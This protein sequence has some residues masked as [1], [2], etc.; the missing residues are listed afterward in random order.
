MNCVKRLNRLL[1]VACNIKVISLFTILLLFTVKYGF[2]ESP[3]DGRPA[4]LSVH[5]IP[6][7]DIHPLTSPSGLD[8]ATIRSVY[9]LPNTGGSG[10]IAIIDAFDDPNIESDLNVFCQQFG[11]PTATQANFELHKMSSTISPATT[12]NWGLEISLDVE[13]AH[14]IAPNAKILLVESV[15]NYTTDFLAAVDYARNRSDVVAI[16]MSWLWPESEIGAYIPDYDS[17]FTSPYG[18]SF[19]ACTGDTGSE[20]NWPSVSVNVTAVGGTYLESTNPVTEV[21]WS[22]SGGGL[23][24]YELEPGYQTSYGV[25]S[26]NGFRAVPDVSYNASDNSPVSV[27]DTIDYGGWITVWGT[28]MGAPQW[29]AIKSLAVGLNMGGNITNSNL[30]LTASNPNT[31]AEDFRDITSGSN[32]SCGYYCN[33]H[34]GYDYVTGLGSPLF[35][36]LLSSQSSQSSQEIWTQLLPTGSLPAPRWGHTAVY[37][38]VNNLMTIFAGGVNGNNVNDLWV[39]SAANGLGGT[40]NWT[41]LSPT[42]GP[43]IGRFRP[44]AIYDTTNNLM[45]IFGGETYNGGDA[46]NDVWVLSNANGLGGTPD[47]TQFSPNPDPTQTTNGFGGLPAA[48]WDHTAVYDNSN[49]IMTI[50]GGYHNDVGDLNDVWVLS[51]ANGLGGTPTWTQLNPIPD[52]V[53]G[54]PTTRDGHTAAY[55]AGNNRMIIF[56]GEAGFETNIFLNDVWVLSNANG[57]GGTPAWTQFS[58]IGSIPTVR[59]YHSAIYDV[60]NNRMTVF[61]GGNSFYSGDFNQ[62][63]VLSNANGLDGTPAWTQL[64]PTPDPVYGLPTTRATH[65]AVYDSANNRMTIFGGY[66]L[67]G[68]YLNNTWVLGDAN[69]LGNGSW[70]NS[71]GTFDAASDTSNFA[72][73]NAPN[74][75]NQPSVN[76]L[77]S[78]QGH[79]GV[80]QLGYNTTSEG[81]KWTSF[82]R[83]IPNPYQPWYRIR[84][85]YYCDSPCSGESILPLILL[86]SDNSSQA[87]QELGAS[88][89]GNSLIQSGNWYTLDAY[90]YCHAN[91][92]Q[93]QLIMRNGGSSGAMYID[94]IEL[95]NIVPPAITNSNPEYVTTIPGVPMS[96]GSDTTHWGFELAYNT[97][98]QP[99]VSWLSSY[100]GQ[101]NV[102]ELNFNNTNQGVKMTSLT[103]DIPAGYNAVMSFNIYMTNP[104]DITA[105]GFLY[106][107]KSLTPFECDIGGYVNVGIIPANTWTTVYVPLSSVSLQTSF[108]LQTLIKNNAHYPEQVYIDNIQLFYSSVEGYDSSLV[109]VNNDEVKHSFMESS[110][111]N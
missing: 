55:D 1:S 25:P 41:Q 92:A 5:A 50:F 20:V 89:T 7:S 42:G 68:S 4:R 38:S 81:L 100:Q 35:G 23:S 79:S 2:S 104:T 110:L 10:T 103:G 14:A 28:S 80:M 66:L 70:D 97:N 56:G 24:N 109:K 44:T 77:S 36:G 22:G 45:T 82:P 90:V 37:D 76:W 6:P 47:W 57:L 96:S 88:Y 13:W 74:I 63:W 111:R 93:L 78:Y 84:V 95:D 91:S 17:N 102:L 31:Y 75:S 9:N 106:G 53:Y 8:P 33:A 29:A 94:S 61:G 27:Y 60:I 52:P 30:Y 58:P 107:E 86:Y 99:K 12:G 85:A 98:S 16:S 71:F 26:T 32:G 19:F 69:G 48:R 59:G 105:E 18:A 83:F 39:L 108:R 21:A 65:T 11:L 67:S 15:T 62:L 73:Q 49:N 72:F 43:P 54:L 87:I 64:N 34:T 46:L 40:P 3:A 101:N 51:N